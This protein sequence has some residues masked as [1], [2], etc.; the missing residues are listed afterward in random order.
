M[1]TH[2]SLTRPR[3]IAIAMFTLVVFL[4]SSATQAQSPKLVAS[5]ASSEV[6]EGESIEFVLELANAEKPGKP[7]VAPLRENF[8]VEDLGDESRNQSS[9]LIVNGRVS[10][11]NSF[12]HIYRYRLKPKTSGSITIPSITAMANG[13]QIESNTL[14]IVVQKPE[15][16]DVVIAEIQSSQDELYPTQS[17][18]LTL[19]I[20]VKPMPETGVEPLRALRKRPPNIQIDWADAPDGLTADDKSEWLRALLA[21]NGFGFT[22]NDFSTQSGSLFDSPRA[23]L[24][25]LSAGRETR[26]DSQ[27]DEIEYYVYEIKRM[28]YAARTGVYNFGPAM[29]KGTFVA[30]V[31]GTEFLG[32]RVVAIAP[33][34]QV[35]VL[36]VPSPRPDGFVGG[37][38]K[39][40]VTATASP[41]KLRVGDPLTLT[42]EFAKGRNSGSLAMISA[43]DL[44][45][46][47]TIAESFDIIDSNPTGRVEGDTKKFAYALRPKKP[48]VTIESIEMSTFDP[49]ERKFTPLSTSPIPLEVTEA[50]ALNSSE[51]V[52]GFS[53]PS[54][55]DIK[56][57]TKGIY[58]N[59]LDPRLVRNQRP[60]FGLYFASLGL[61][62]LLTAGTVIAIQFA[63][64]RSVDTTK[65]RRQ[66]ATRTALNKLGQILYQKGGDV[67]TEQLRMVRSAFVGLVA[68]T[69][70]RLVDGLTPSDVLK[71]LEQQQVLDEDRAVVQRILSTR[72]SCEYGAHDSMDMEKLVAEASNVIRRIGPKLERKTK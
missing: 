26:K 20:L 72:E 71:A 8:I 42:L 11:R 61:M 53:K 50:S 33:A 7:D 25:D 23:A 37:V 32:K 70:N 30:G 49:T 66:R 18:A 69:H 14:T 19:R 46:S 43:P 68:D 59:M 41:M 9:T 13:S 6:Y 5:V 63:R 17:F 35:T 39:Y 58:Q 36:D 54:N 67:D 31:E 55:S 64:G 38:G 1:H 10:Q 12:S 3:L 15:E 56:L 40:Q 47:P 45:L 21:K 22:L 52:G 51:L 16:Q 28:F 48:G 24:F 60:N 2:Y 65:Q 62:G 57:S 44:S 29:I 4:F 34:K 27:G